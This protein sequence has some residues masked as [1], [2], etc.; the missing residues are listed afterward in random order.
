[1]S[2]RIFEDE[3]SIQLQLTVFKLLIKLKIRKFNSDYLYG[4]MINMKFPNHDLFHKFHNQSSCV[5]FQLHK[6]KHFQEYILA[7]A[8]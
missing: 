8:A 1:V 7:I 2:Y 6:K 5:S 4:K 3:M